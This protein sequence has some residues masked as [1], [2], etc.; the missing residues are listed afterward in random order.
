[1]A[2]ERPPV[3]FLDAGLLEMSTIWAAAG[4]PTTVFSLSP[5]ELV[6]LTGGRVAN[7]TS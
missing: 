3:T 5:A 2:H 6:R 1:M 4:T 7:V